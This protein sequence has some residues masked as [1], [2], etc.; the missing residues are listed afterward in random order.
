MADFR[1]FEL[2]RKLKMSSKELLVKIGQLK[3]SAKSHL[4]GITKDQAKR[5]ENAIK[6]Q[7]AH[8][9]MLKRAATGRSAKTA[10][11]VTRKKGKKPSQARPAEKG[12]A[13][14]KAAGRGSA[15]R[16][17]APVSEA[18]QRALKERFAPLPEK[19]RVDRDHRK[20]RKSAASR[21]DGSAPARSSC[22]AE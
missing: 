3:I 14:G 11:P 5:I 19:T 16:A 21:Q 22:H 10:K 7:R 18:K 12:A 8:K 1:V 9:T 20:G 15:R 13:V 2:A 6:A 4:S 17:K